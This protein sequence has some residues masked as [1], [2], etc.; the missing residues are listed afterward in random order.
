M[1]LLCER[2]SEAKMSLYA[3]VVPWLVNDLSIT[4]EKI[5]NVL[6]KGAESRVCSEFTEQE[7]WQLL[8]LP[9]HVTVFLLSLVP[10]VA[11]LSCSSTRQQPRVH[12]EFPT[13]TDRSHAWDM[14]VHMNAE[15]C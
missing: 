15:P 3:Q 12:T 6:S 10:R 4:S 13:R 7:Y 5:L 1:N 9:I 14:H 2:L 8:K 11:F